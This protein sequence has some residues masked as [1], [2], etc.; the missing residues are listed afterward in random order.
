MG[1]YLDIAT[2]S[3][4]V[5]R[6]D[7]TDDKGLGGFAASKNGN[8]GDRSNTGDDGAVFFVADQRQRNRRLLADRGEPGEI[9]ESSERRSGEISLRCIHG[10]TVSVCDLCS[11]YARWLIAG[12]DARIAEARSNPEAA[13][14]AFW[15]EAAMVS[16]LPRQRN[17]EMPDGGPPPSGRHRVRRATCPH[18]NS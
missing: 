9:S 2:S 14:R 4:Q 16:R 18:Q 13:R 17:G 6:H 11:G 7:S 8:A 12:G 3:T 10:T 15:R 5:Q 1:R